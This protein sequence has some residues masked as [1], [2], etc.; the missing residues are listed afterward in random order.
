MEADTADVLLGLEVL[1][2][3]HLVAFYFQ[4]HQPPVVETHLVAISKMT[5]DDF[6][7]TNVRIP[8]IAVHQF[9]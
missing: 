7:Q 2:G 3:I 5:V 1:W 8:A 9:R 6:R 4:L